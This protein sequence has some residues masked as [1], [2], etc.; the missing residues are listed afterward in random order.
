MERRST[1]GVFSSSRH[2]KREGEKRKRKKTRRERRDKKSWY[3]ICIF[4]AELY[5]RLSSIDSR[6]GLDR[7]VGIII[8]MLI[9]TKPSF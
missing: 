9:Y 2:K 6:L 3:E 7:S 1:S 4:K 5:G 8:F